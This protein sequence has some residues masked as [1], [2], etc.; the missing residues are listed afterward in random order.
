MLYGNVKTVI[1]AWIEFHDFKFNDIFSNDKV[2]RSFWPI[3]TL[4]GFTEYSF[5]IKFNKQ[6]K[7]NNLKYQPTSKLLWKYIKRYC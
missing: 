7:K 5:S 1:I 6:K 2:V 3:H 4:I